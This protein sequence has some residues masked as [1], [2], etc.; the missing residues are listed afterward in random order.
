MKKVIKQLIA[1]FRPIKGHGTI[2]MYQRAIVYSEWVLIVSVTLSV[3]LEVYNTE[4]T[5]WIQFFENYAIGTACSVV[6]VIV[7]TLIQFFHFSNQ[8]INK[9]Y[10]NLDRLQCSL[11]LIL[12]RKKELNGELPLAK[13]KRMLKPL[14]EYELLS[15]ELF[16]FRTKIEKQYKVLEVKLLKLVLLYKYKPEDLI[17]LSESDIMNTV[18]SIHNF[19]KL[20]RPKTNDSYDDLYEDN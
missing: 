17:L 18:N 20:L 15:E 10:S 19:L 8:Q 1:V 16:W 4:H 3:V 6:I 11:I 13:Y 5:G 7:T 14:E 2:G 9:A 12:D